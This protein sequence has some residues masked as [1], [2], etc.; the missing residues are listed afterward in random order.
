MGK[1]RIVVL[2]GAGISAESGL[3]TF[4]DADGLWENHP[5]AEVATHEALER[6][7]KAVYDFANMLRRN[8]QKAEPNLGH[9]LLAELEK[10]YEVVILTQNIDDLH[11][12]AGSSNVLHL[13]GELMKACTMERPDLP[14]PLPNDTLEINPGD[15]D[16]SGHL[17]RPFIVYFGEDVPN[18]TKAM[19]ETEKADLFV[20]IGSSLNVY[21]VAGLLYYVPDGAPCYVIDPKP[22]QSPYRK[23]EQIQLSASEGMTV[24]IKRLRS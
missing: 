9:R 21:P 23:F 1:K 12:R 11:E 20:V 7:P 19:K 6:N 17:L 24:L 15:K 4:R 18:Y 10:D 22:V 8:L 2:T 14:I 13:H 5:V 3:S 16:E